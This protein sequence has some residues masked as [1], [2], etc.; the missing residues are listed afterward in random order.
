M[1]SHELTGPFPYPS[2][3]LWKA[4]ARSPILLWRMGLEKVLGQVFA[5]ITVTGRKSGLSRRIVTEYCPYRGKLYIPAAYAPRAQWYRNLMAD[6]RATVQTWQGAESLRVT[7]VTDPDELVAVCAAFRRRNPLMMDAY[8]RGL[9][10]Q[11]GDAVELAAKRDR[12]YILRFDPI[13][14]PTPPPLE[15]D[16][17]WVWPVALG[18]LLLW[19]RLRRRRNDRS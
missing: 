17:R 8:L 10:I 3:P 4:L 6:P 9:G 18:A 5:L 14:A 1:A 11:P 13:D 2:H 15:A 16:L 12:V 19:Q 7:R